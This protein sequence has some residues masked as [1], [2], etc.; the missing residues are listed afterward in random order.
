M[1]VFPVQVTM[2][3]IG[4]LTLLIHTLIYYV[5]TIHIYIHAPSA[6]FLEYAV[7]DH[8]WRGPSALFAG[9]TFYT[10]TDHYRFSADHCLE[11]DYVFM[12]IFGLV[13]ALTRVLVIEAMFSRVLC[14]MTFG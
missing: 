3:R 7:P 5:M 8:Y 2:S 12:L 10:S 11:S 6:L 13:F 4:N 1:V 9:A 14:G